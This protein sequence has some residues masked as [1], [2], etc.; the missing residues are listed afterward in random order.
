MAQSLDIGFVPDIMSRVKRS[1]PQAHSSGKAS[2]LKLGAKEVFR[3]KEGSEYVEKYPYILLID[4]V[5]TTGATMESCATALMDAG[6]EEI[7]GAV[8]AH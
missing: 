7:W 5:F 1:N 3:A 8:V 4:D 6:F 2:R